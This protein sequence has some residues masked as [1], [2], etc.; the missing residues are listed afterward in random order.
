MDT[1]DDKPVFI[2][3]DEY[4]SQVKTFATLGYS[5]QRICTLLQLKGKEKFALSVRMSMPGDVYYEAWQNGKA[6]GQYNI[7]SELAK[8]AEKGDVDAIN[9]LAERK[10]ERAE[11]ELRK[12]LFGI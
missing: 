5:V 7:D 4:V 10:R 1:A 2:I 6:T 3:G 11:A 8:K 12:E 9:L